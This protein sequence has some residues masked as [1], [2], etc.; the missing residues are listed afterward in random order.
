MTTFWDM[1]DSSCK[2]FPYSDIVEDKAVALWGLPLNCDAL[3]QPHSST[4]CITMTSALTFV[5]VSK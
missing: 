2:M 3:K 1:N 4:H 5:D